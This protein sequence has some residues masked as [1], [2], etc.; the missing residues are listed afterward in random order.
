MI[1]EMLKGGA[2]GDAFGFG[3]EMQDRQNLQNISYDAWPQ[4]RTGEYAVNTHPGD[5]SDDTEH[6]IGLVKALLSGKEFT[7]ELLLE[8]WRAEYES[9]KL[10][11]G[12]PRAGHGS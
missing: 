10:K 5:Y 4:M 9:D 12:Y 3:A 2:I 1:S 6:T 11:K 8:F 7:E